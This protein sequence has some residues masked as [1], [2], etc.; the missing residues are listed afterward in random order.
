MGVVFFSKPRR[1]LL[2][3]QFAFLPAQIVTVTF[4]AAIGCSRVTGPAVSADLVVQ[5]DFLGELLLG[6]ISDGHGSFLSQDFV[7]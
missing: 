7:T 4:P 2:C 3:S 5:P 1:V 6:D